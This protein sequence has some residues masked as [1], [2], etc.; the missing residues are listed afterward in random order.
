M[1]NQLIKFHDVGF[2][3][4]HKVCF[5]SFNATIFEGQKVAIIGNNGA[6][7]STLLRMMVQ[8]IPVELGHITI[9]PGVRIG[10]VPQVMTM[11]DT[12]S[13]GEHFNRRLSKV[14][15]HAPDILL[16]DEPTNH[17]DQKNRD[18][19]V[20]MLKNS[21]KTL[22]VAT[23]DEELL[24]TMFD[25][26]WSI[27]EG[28]IQIF[29]GQFA[30]F[31]D[32]K[33][34][35]R[36]MLVHK[37]SLLKKVEEKMH[38]AL[39]QE[40]QRAKKSRL[41]G[42]KSI[43]NKKWPTIVSSAKAR[44]AEETAGKK[45]SQVRHER[46]EIAK[47][48]A[49]AFLAEIVAPQFYFSSPRTPRGVI[50]SVQQGSIGYKDHTLLHDV[51]WSL[52]YGERIALVG[53]NGCGKSS[54]FKALLKDPTCT[55]HGLWQC[56]P[57]HEIGYL[58]QSYE[59]LVSDRTVLSTITELCPQWNLQEV[60]RHLNDFLFRKNEEV[61]IKVK[62]LSGG[63]K[64]RLSLCAIAAKAPS[65]LLLDE[66]TNNLDFS[67]KKHVIK[68]LNSYKGAL[69]VISHDPAFLLELNLSRMYEI[70]DHEIHSKA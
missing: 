36:A 56:P 25:V 51:N 65:V 39:M 5:S 32:L 64:A 22:V 21:S 24:R 14:L 45:K 27:D 60:R 28:D 40:Q 49:K 11:R 17:L 31:L 38:Q 9:L 42:E 62:D 26:F 15:A 6:G 20:S 68:V 69:V 19:L 33:E 23:H 46:D 3:L 41:K 16:L 44:R 29:T 18:A 70:R 1:S 35:K 43:V 63:E 37:R 50:I 58:S 66:I 13:G 8:E 4:P 53:N 48:F 7:K 10:Y 55:R 59:N 67:T 30:D 54:F 61:S 57:L 52:S 34:K 12:L 2:C 47:E